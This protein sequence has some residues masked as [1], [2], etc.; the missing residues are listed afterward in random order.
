MKYAI[1]EIAPGLRRSLVVLMNIMT[2]DVGISDLEFPETGVRKLIILLPHIY[3]EAS[4]MLAH[5]RKNTGPSSL[6]GSDCTAGH[7]DD[8]FV[9]KTPVLG[10]LH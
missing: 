10:L 4:Q 2:V 1:Q 3:G 7:G 6:F 5:N 9:T 8:G